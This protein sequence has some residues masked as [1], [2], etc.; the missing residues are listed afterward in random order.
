[1]NSTVQNAIL[2]QNKSNKMDEKLI[3]DLDETTRAQDDGL[4]SI[5]SRLGAYI[6]D[7][8]IMQVAFALIQTGYYYYLT[9]SNA[10]PDKHIADNIIWISCIIFTWLYCTISESSRFQGT[11]G[12]MIFR[13]K[14]T[15][16]EKNRI[17]FARA[18]TRYLYK[19]FIPQCITLFVLIK[20]MLQ[21][22]GGISGTDA[23]YIS[24]FLMFA[25]CVVAI[26]HIE[27]KA[28][29][30]IMAKTLVFKKF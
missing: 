25:T 9:Y 5:W 22:D 21:P 24:W 27:R 6:I 7:G 13:M 14:I 30:D 19:N 10:S 29:H 17:S 16:S 8:I 2:K 18:N 28:F 20:K 12:K 23:Y 15:D 3:L 1:M 26:F 4:A 11:L